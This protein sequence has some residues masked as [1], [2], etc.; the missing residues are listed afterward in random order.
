MD[1]DDEDHDRLVAAR[2]K[3]LADGMKLV[4]T[5]YVLVECG[6]L[7]LRR[8]GIEAFRAL[9]V[10]SREPFNFFCVDEPMRREA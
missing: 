4:T 2:K 7:V 8:F 10:A 6:A 1:K 5:S 9:G 3:L